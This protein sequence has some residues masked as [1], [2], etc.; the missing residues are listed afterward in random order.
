MKLENPT[1][2]REILH[3]KNDLI[4]QQTRRIRLLEEKLTEIRQKY[5]SLKISLNM[6]K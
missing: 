1:E 3:D 6:I 2:L 5:L 4:V